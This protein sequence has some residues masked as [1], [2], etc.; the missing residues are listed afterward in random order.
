MQYFE[1]AAGAGYSDSQFYLGLM[2]FNG[3]G[4]ERDYRKAL[5]QFSLAAQQGHLISIYNLGL[6]HATGT[7]V[8]RSCEV[9][10]DTRIAGVE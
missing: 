3:L 7:G 8:A 1:R 9:R 10:C 4:V 2:Y 6:M 5:Q